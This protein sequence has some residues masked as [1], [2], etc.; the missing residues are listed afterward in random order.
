MTIVMGYPI[1]SEWFEMILKMK[2]WLTDVAYE[3]QKV[4]IEQD[5]DHDTPHPIRS[6][7]HMEEQEN[8]II[9]IKMKDHANAKMIIRVWL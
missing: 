1:N 2:E 8:M 7:E 5:I 9:M 6:I 4:G 3:P